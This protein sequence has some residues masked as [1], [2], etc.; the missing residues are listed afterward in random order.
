MN[1]EL[2]STKPLGL[3]T[4]WWDIF[5]HESDFKITVTEKNLETEGLTGETALCRFIAVFFPEAFR[6][7]RQILDDLDAL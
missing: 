1:K 2:V 6:A 7:L 3:P 5:H 4:L